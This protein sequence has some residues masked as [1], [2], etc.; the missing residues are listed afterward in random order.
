MNRA[1]ERLVTLRVRHVM[2]PE[3]VQL[4]VSDTMATAAVT[5]ADHHISGVPVA[6]EQ[7]RCVG[8]LSAADFVNRESKH[9]SAPPPDVGEPFSWVRE[10]GGSLCLQHIPEGVVGAHMSRAV[11]TISADAS[12]LEAGRIMC[13]EHVHRLP[14]LDSDGRAVGLVSS[15]DLVAAMIGIAEEH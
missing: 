14:V 2:S 4:R 5:L 9:E 6:D 3:V 13:A 10:S 7:G 1:F 12:M 8:I 11:Q 15:L